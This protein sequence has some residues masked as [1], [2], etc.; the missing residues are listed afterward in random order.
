M[1]QWSYLKYE[2]TR[3][4]R[5]VFLACM[6]RLAYNRPSLCSI[7]FLACNCLHLCG[8]HFKR[9]NQSLLVTSFSSPAPAQVSTAPFFRH[10]RLSATIRNAI[11]HLQPLKTSFRSRSKN[12][13][14]WTHVQPV[15]GTVRRKDF[16]KELY[17][18]GNNHNK[19]VS[20]LPA[21]SVPSHLTLPK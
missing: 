14:S 17:M 16:T 18:N 12:Q 20:V 6:Q 9:A 3:K 5:L 1:G 10:S 15:F 8:P 11:W 2:A 4:D 21:P 13:I 19:N 7:V